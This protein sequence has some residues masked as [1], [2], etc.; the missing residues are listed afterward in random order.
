MTAAGVWN[1][2]TGD[3]IGR[4]T[5]T[6][7]GLDGLLNGPGEAVA[8]LC[9]LWVIPGER[10]LL[11]EG[12]G[13]VCWLPGEVQNGKWVLLLPPCDEPGLCEYIL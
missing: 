3:L 7:L 8:R 9:G 1:A 13:E 5:F 11:G 2:A 6:G 10:R 12:S 4:G